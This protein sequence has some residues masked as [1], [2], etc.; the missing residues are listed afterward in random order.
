VQLESRGR[1]DEDGWLPRG[2]EHGSVARLDGPYLVCGGWWRARVDRDYYF[3]HMR[4]GDVL[5]IYYD[6]GRRRWFWQGEVS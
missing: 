6:R 3:A 4:S 5:W 1:H 2:L